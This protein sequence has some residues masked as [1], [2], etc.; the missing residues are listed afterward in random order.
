MHHLAV[1]PLIAIL[2]IAVIAFVAIAIINKSFTGEAA[3]FAWIARLIVG[4]L[5]LV[6]LY[7]VFL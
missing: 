7:N 4:I 5:A 3:E 2:V 6:A 1:S